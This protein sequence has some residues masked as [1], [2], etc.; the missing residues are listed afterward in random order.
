MGLKNIAISQDNYEIL[1]NFGKAGM[2]FND[3][4][5]ELIMTKVQTA[6]KPCLSDNIEKIRPEQR[7]PNHTQTVSSPANPDI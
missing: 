2:S 1:R 3:V 4:I 6:N 5:S 7:R